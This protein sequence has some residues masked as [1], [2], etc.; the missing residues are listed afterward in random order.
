[1]EIYILIVYY[2]AIYQL[3]KKFYENKLKISYTILNPFYNESDFYLFE[4]VKKQT[5]NKTFNLVIAD[6]NINNEKFFSYFLFKFFKP[7]M[8]IIDRNT[9]DSMSFIQKEIF[10]ISEMKYRKINFFWEFLIYMLEAYKV[11]NFVIF[12]PFLRYKRLKIDKYLYKIYGEIYLELLCKLSYEKNI[13]SILYKLS[14]NFTF[15]NLIQL[16]FYDY[17]NSIRI[18]YLVETKI[19]RIIY[20]KFTNKIKKIIKK[21]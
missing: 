15:M 8:S 9:W 19:N 18:Y 11:F 2:F 6:N 4:K 16:L 20:K 17:F 7:N 10:L 13:K 5:N 14:D 12:Y 21:D 3:T 1:M